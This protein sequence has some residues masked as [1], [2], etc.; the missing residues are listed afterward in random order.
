[1]QS[2]DATVKRQVP[3]KLRRAVDGID[4]PADVRALI[5]FA[6]LLTQQAHVGETLLDTVAKGARGLPSRP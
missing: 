1:M 4:D 2:D 5:A 6:Q 3:G